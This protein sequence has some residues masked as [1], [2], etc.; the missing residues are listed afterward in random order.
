MNI[1]RGNTSGTANSQIWDLPMVLNSYTLV[2]RT[3]GSINFSIYMINDSDVISVG[4]GSINSGAYHTDEIPR[5]VRVNENVRLVTTGS[6]DYDFE[7]D[8]TQPPA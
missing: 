7:F 6:T 5:L 1:F 3:G 8:N 4:Q 2:N